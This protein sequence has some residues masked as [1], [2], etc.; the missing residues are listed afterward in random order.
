MLLLAIRTWRPCALRLP[1]PLMKHPIVIAAAASL[2]WTGVAAALSS[3]PLVSFKLL[4]VRD[5]QAAVYFGGGIIVLSTLRSTR[6][7]AV[8]GA[9]GLA[10]VAVWSIFRSQLL[11]GWQAMYASAMPFFPNRLELTVVAAFWL[12]ALWGSRRRGD[13]SWLIALPLAAA[14]VLLRGRAALIA[15]AVGTAAWWV[16]RQRTR[17]VLV[18]ATLLLTTVFAGALA[19]DLW[20]WRESGDQ[21]FRRTTVL[22]PVWE[23]V[24]A[25]TLAADESFLERTNRWRC[26]LLM[27][28]ER[29]LVGFGPGAFEREYGVYQRARDRTRWSTDRGDL[30]DAH[31][32]PLGRLAEEGVPGAALQLFFLAA[33]VFSGL[34]AARTARDS[35][36]VN[37]AAAWTGAVVALATAS[38]FVGISDLSGTGLA[39]WLAAAVLLRLDMIAAQT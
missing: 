22:E 1:G 11:D 19:K 38:L 8:V 5:L 7:L 39:P 28:A 3:S 18:A 31:S 4:L 36:V 12:L 20:L 15:T 32:E 13:R 2:A 29:P 27:A 34:R 16:V 9:L 25:S 21:P 10:P 26:A 35:A 23:T 17:P 14:M 37:A 6:R 33:I 30:G 24:S